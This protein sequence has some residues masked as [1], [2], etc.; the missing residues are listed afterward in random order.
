MMKHRYGMYQMDRKDAVGPVEGR[1]QPT[2]SCNVCR[3]SEG[4]SLITSI[5]TSLKRELCHHNTLAITS[6]HARAAYRA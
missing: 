1:K 5:L 4:E 3:Q 6:G 2:L